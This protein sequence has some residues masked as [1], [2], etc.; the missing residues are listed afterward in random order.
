MMWN[1]EWKKGVDYP[2]WGDTDVYKKK[3]AVNQL[4]KP[5]LTI[6]RVKKLSKKAQY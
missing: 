6:R 1:N 3:I 5:S 2:A 4:K